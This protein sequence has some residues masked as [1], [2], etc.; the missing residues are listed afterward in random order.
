MDT[1]IL[2]N[3]ILLEAEKEVVCGWK[4]EGEYA[5]YNLP[6]CAEM[7]EKQMGFFNPLREK[8]YRAYY[9]GSRFVG[10]TNLLETEA[11]VFVGIGVNPAFCSQGY[12]QH[13]L[14]EACNISRQRYPG[15]PLYL[16][17][18]TWNAR[19]IRCYQ[20]AGF[21]IDGPAFEQETGIGRGTFYRM[22][23]A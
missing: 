2:E 10:F 3:H 17:V 5:I 16:E 9:H 7:R 6:S 20:K 11:G 4:Y 13:I 22:V 18:R 12:G 15:K 1:V 19:A 23:L 8:H 21:Q 14:Q